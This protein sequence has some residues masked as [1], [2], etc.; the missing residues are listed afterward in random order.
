MKAPAVKWDPW[1]T[2]NVSKE[3][4]DLA[5]QRRE[6]AEQRKLDFKRMIE[7]PRIHTG[8]GGTLFD[9][10][11]QRWYSARMTKARTYSYGRNSPWALVTFYFVPLFLLVT[12]MRSERSSRLAGMKTGEVKTKGKMFKRLFF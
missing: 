5:L 2:F 6:Q 11:I 4:M 8:K 3:K 1:S 10:A 12:S 7:N 9:P